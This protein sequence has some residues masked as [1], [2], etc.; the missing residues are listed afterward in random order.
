LRVI[1]ELDFE[2]FCNYISYYTKWSFNLEGGWRGIKVCFKEPLMKNSSRGSF[3][4]FNELR[5]ILN[6]ILS[7]F[8]IT[9]ATTQNG[10]LTWEEDGGG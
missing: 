4:S 8:A 6:L 7:I 2:H 9:L 1:F 3:Q 5:V 10:A